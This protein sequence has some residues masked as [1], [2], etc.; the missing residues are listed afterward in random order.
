MSHSCYIKRYRAQPIFERTAHSFD[1]AI[2][3]AATESLSS[4]FFENPRRGENRLALILL[5]SA[6]GI[7]PST[8]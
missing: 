4:S 2:K 5:V 3:V 6:D 7:E 1:H 8:Y